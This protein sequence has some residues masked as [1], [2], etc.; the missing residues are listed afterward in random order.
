MIL[1]VHYNKHDDLVLYFAASRDTA[2][3]ETA[4]PAKKLSDSI[5]CNTKVEYQKDL[6]F[7]N[8]FITTFSF[9]WFSDYAPNNR[10]CL[11]F[12]H[13]LNGKNMETLE[14][15]FPDFVVGSE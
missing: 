14:K 12:L 1:L 5:Y 2:H 9:L 13:F 10:F 3:H 6:H 11:I 4:K 7:G 15:S 8:G